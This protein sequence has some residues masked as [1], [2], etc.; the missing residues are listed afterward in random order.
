MCRPASYFFCKLPDQL[1]SRRVAKSS[2][3]G[4]DDVRIGQGNQR[5]RRFDHFQHLD[6]NVLF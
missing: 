2:A 1:K 4:A 6:M 5:L 3:A